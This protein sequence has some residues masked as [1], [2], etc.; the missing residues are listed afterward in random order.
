[1]TFSWQW[2][3]GFILCF[4]AMAWFPAILSRKVWLYRYDYGFS[5]HCYQVNKKHAGGY[6]IFYLTNIQIN[7]KNG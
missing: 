6:L 1:M 2:Y 4:G 7:T 5:T 3:S